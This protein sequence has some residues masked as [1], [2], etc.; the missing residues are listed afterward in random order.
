MIKR[1][2]KKEV[3][4]NTLSTGCS[5]CLKEA[6]KIHRKIGNRKVSE[7]K[8]AEVKKIISSLFNKKE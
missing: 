5:P 1:A 3:N 7:I 2:T 4:L 6:E 8:I